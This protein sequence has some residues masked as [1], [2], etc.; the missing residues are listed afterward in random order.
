MENG[1]EWKILPSCSLPADVPKTYSFLKWSCKIEQ[2]VVLGGSR[3]RN[4]SSEWFPTPSCPRRLPQAARGHQPC[5]C[6]RLCLWGVGA[7]EKAGFIFVVTLEIG[8]WEG[9][10]HLDLILGCRLESHCWRQELSGKNFD[11]QWHQGGQS[12]RSLACSMWAGGA[13]GRQGTG[14]C[15]ELGTSCCHGWIGEGGVENSAQGQ[16]C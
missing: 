6:L 3:L 12:A 13:H 16:V 2:S 9:I 5:H 11:M 4:A 1:S 15:G 7:R 10:C 14:F 8:P